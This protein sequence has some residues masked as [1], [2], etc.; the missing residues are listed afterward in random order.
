[1]A[2]FRIERGFVQRFMNGNWVNVTSS[3]HPTDDEAAKV[4]LK[5]LVD[6]LDRMQSIEV[7]MH[8]IANAASE[9]TNWEG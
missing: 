3:T 4:T 5:M 1:M 6:L 7:L 9:I 2:T 8:I